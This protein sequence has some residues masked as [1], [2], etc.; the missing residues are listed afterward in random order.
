MRFVLPIAQIVANVQKH[1][2]HVQQN[3]QPAPTNVFGNNRKPVEGEYIDYEE[4]R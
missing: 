4:L 3:G 2:K 1:M